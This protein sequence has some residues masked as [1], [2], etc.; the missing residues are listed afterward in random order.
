MYLQIIMQLFEMPVLA[1]K[2]VEMF[3]SWP[4][5]SDYNELFTSIVHFS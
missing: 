2:N 5:I 3:E 4:E 1:K